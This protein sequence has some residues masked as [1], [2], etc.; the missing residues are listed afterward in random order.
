[1]DADA[2]C[3]HATPRPGLARTCTPAKY[4]QPCAGLR[5]RLRPDVAGSRPARRPS[6]VR[7]LAPSAPMPTARVSRDRQMLRYQIL[8]SAGLIASP[9]TGP[10]PIGR[11]QTTARMIAS[12]EP[13][14]A[15]SAMNCCVM[16]RRAGCAKRCR[17][18]GVTLTGEASSCALG[19]TVRRHAM[20]R[21]AACRAR[22]AAPALESSNDGR[23]NQQI[24]HGRAD[25]ARGADGTKHPWARKDTDGALPER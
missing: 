24:C 13:A 4:P 1:M 23:Q 17:G 10:R 22:D 25:G 21:G 20:R 12:D 14:R 11:M 16:S 7:R 2:S 18:S 6:G 5:D 15:A 9:L 8:L 3:R 19:G